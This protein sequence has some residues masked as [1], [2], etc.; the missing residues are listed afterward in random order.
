MIVPG[1]EVVLRTGESVFSYRTDLDG[2]VV[3]FAGVTVGVD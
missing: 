2:T 1:Y 3:R